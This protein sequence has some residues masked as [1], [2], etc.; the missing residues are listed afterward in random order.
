MQRIARPTMRLKSTEYLTVDVGIPDARI[1]DR[2]R[3]GNADVLRH[4]S[5]RRFM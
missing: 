2:H 1:D 5:P 3:I 4:R